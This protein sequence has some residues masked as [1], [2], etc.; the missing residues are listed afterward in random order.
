MKNNKGYSLVELMVVVA[1]LGIVSSAVVGLVIACT[2]SYRNVNQ[3]TNLQN[4]AQVAMNQIENMLIDATNGVSYYLGNNENN[5]VVSDD[6]SDGTSTKKTLVIYNKEEVLNVIWVSKD[7]KLYFRKDARSAESGYVTKGEEALMAEYV[8][9]FSVSL[10]N[11]KKKG[12]VNVLLSFKTDERK[13]YDLNQNIT[14]RNVSVVNGELTDV[15]PDQEVGL[16]SVIS[17]SI[18]N[19]NVDCT[20][21]S[22]TMS[23][24]DSGDTKGSIS[25]S[26]LIKGTGYPSQDV[27]WSVTGNNDENTTISGGKLT[28]GKDESASS[29]RVI[30]TSKQDNEKSAYV[31]VFLNSITGLSLTVSGHSGDYRKGDTFIVTAKVSGN[32]LSESDKRLEWSVSGATRD[33]SYASDGLTQKFK[34]TA[35]PG[36]Q[37]TVSAT[38]I[39]NRNISN[40][41]NPIIVVKTPYAISIT[42]NSTWIYRG[43][44][45][46]YTANVDPNDGSYG[47]IEWIT[48][49]YKFYWSNGQW[50]EEKI[51]PT[52]FCSISHTGNKNTITFKNVSRECNYKLVVTARLK[53]NPN[54]SAKVE[55]VLWTNN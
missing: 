26:T 46:I 38:C 14:M 18:F 7:K 12:V 1:I 20:N 2:R 11:A 21:S 54:V 4:E 30:V 31:D 40:S 37:V 10:V 29:V 36:Q 3:E 53:N 16:S 23:V 6:E 43:G 13:T 17:V 44:T 50:V 48:E 55:D 25:F 34:I 45:V 41:I 5:K 22:V 33:T 19:G 51:K 15:Y 52:L 39:A 35:D 42:R 24:S 9:N 32:H 8:E 47:E 27:V 49:G 28:I